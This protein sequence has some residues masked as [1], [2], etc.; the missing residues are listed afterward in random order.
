[1]TSRVTTR[2]ST[3]SMAF[4]LFARLADAS[5]SLAS[6]APVPAL[7]LAAATAV[8]II[9]LVAVRQHNRTYVLRTELDDTPGGQGE[10][11]GLCSHRF[12]VFAYAARPWK[13]YG[14]EMG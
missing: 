13:T 6:L 7:S 11:S 3:G 8:A 12:P 14:R 1:M 5:Q 4:D 2:P 9:N 10:Q